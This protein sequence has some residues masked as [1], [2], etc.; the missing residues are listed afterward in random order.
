MLWGFYRPPGA[1]QHGAGS[2]RGRRP[3]P[4]AVFFQAG[5]DGAV[6]GAFVSTAGSVLTG[7]QTYDESGA[8]EA[9]RGPGAERPGRES[10]VRVPGLEGHRKTSPL[11][12][13]LNAHAPTRPPMTARSGA[14]AVGRLLRS[15]SAAVSPEHRVAV[16]RSREYLGEHGEL[17]HG[18]RLKSRPCA[19]LSCKAPG[20]LRSGRDAVRSWT[21]SYLADGGQ[22]LPEHWTP[23]SIPL[24]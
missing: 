5:G 16:L 17:T 2:S 20:L 12:P 6:V 1:A 9:N 24:S 15:W 7:F 19:C 23:R 3:W 10:A 14:R 4:P 21:R 22:V 18:L 11:G 8:P 13:P